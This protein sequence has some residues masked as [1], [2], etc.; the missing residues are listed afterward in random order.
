MKLLENR[1]K[2]QI[3]ISQFQ[4]KMTQ[5]PFPIVRPQRI[6]GIG[7]IQIY[8]RYG[9]K[10]QG[11]AAHFGHSVTIAFQME[12]FDKI[13]TRMVKALAWLESVKD[14]S[15]LPKLYQRHKPVIPK[16]TDHDE[17]M[18]AMFSADRRGLRFA[19][20]DGGRAAAGFENGAPDCFARA[21]CHHTGAEYKQVYDTVYHG[22]IKNR[23]DNFEAIGVEEYN[24]EVVWSDY[25]VS[26]KATAW[27]QNALGWDEQWVWK[28]IS[29]SK[30]YK[31]FGDCI[32]ITHR[33]AAAIQDGVLLDTFNS[34][35]KK[36]NRVYKQCSEDEAAELRAKAARLID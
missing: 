14:L 13:L 26:K 10:Y 12:D 28:R 33:H 25:L 23:P 17:I 29:A 5:P 22:D 24:L 31:V 21:I 18:D 35:R 19:H 7:G 30:A 4:P 20:S 8:K 3:T 6:E 32:V 16:T 11:R 34:L 27:Q 2:K 36:V 9:N 1:I 15:D